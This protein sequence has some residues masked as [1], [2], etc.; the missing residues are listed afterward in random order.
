MTI[1]YYLLIILGLSGFISANASE[2]KASGLPQ[3]DFTTYPSLI[4]WSI[5]SLIILYLEIYFLIMPKISLILNNREQNIQNNLMKAKSIK[6]ESDSIIEKLYKEQDEARKKA[7]DML[8]LTII[9]SKSE[10]ENKQNEMTNKMNIK[11]DNAR[12]SLN[13]EKN[14]KLLQLLENA[15]AY[16]EMIISKVIGFEVNKN[17]LNAIHKTES[18]KIIKENQNGI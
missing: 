9:Q 12:T 5:L 18:A 13:K 6:E 11:I 8:D 14:L 4:F 10:N 15:N 16:S 3:L 7:R 1:L 17:K 2:N